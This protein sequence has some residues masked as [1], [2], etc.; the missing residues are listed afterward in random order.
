MKASKQASILT[1]L[2]GAVHLGARPQQQ[3]GHIRVEVAG[4]LHERRAPRH[5]HRRLY[6]HSSPQQRLHHSGA[7]VLGGHQQR[8]PT[9]GAGDA[10]R[11]ELALL[12]GPQE[13]LHLGSVSLARR[14]Q[15]LCTHD[16][17]RT[18]LA[19]CSK[20]GITSMTDDNNCMIKLVLE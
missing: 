1:L 18:V 3:L 9:V 20:H 13:L 10:A 6:V 14:Q 5:H 8:R 19:M 12:V 11:R 16:Q 15:D 2:V 7:A 4:R 17:S